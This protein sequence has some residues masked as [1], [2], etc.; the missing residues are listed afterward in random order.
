MTPE[1]PK[2][3]GSSVMLSTPVIPQENESPSLGQEDALESNLLLACYFSTSVHIMQR[4]QNTSAGF[5]LND[6]K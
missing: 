1:C 3:Q 2:C 6:S 4:P 5:L